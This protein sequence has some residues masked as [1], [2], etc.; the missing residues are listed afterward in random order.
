[1]KVIVAG[2]PKTGTK[3]MQAALT[4]LGY[5]VYDYEENVLFL[6]DEWRKIYSEGGSTEDFYEMYKNV[7]AVTDVPPCYF[8]DEIH[9]AF[10][11]SKV[12]RSS[13]LSLET[14]W[15]FGFAE[16]EK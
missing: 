1:M 16:D 12:R 3:T 6:N 15:L 5:K 14:I 4:E 9:K 13:C 7:D 2:M 11:E 8:W 10:P